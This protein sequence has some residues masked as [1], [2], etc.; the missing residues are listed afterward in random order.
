VTGQFEDFVDAEGL[1]PAERDRLRRVHE[2]L[3]AAGPPPELSVGLATLA[4]GSTEALV[5]RF[6]QARRRLAGALVLAAALAA[7]AFGGGFLVGHGSGGSSKV[8]RVAAMRGSNAVASIRVGA[9]DA[10]GNW[11][12]DFNVSGLAKQAGNY[13]YY[14]VF[15]VHNGKPGYPCGGFRV[16]HGAARLRFWVPYEVTASTAWVVTAIDGAHAWPGR[17]VMTMA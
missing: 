10:G 5:I 17:T 1:D 11:P 12:V 9:P 8:V 14:E 2:L 16:L 13:S 6:P 3:V 7:A 15:V 4:A